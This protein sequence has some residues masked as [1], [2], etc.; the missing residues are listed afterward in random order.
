[1]TDLAEH[2]TTPTRSSPLRAGSTLAIGL[3]AGFGLG[4]VARAWMRLISED[5]EFT[6]AGTLFIVVGF[7]IC[8]FV[9]SI[10]AVAR[11]RLTQRWKLTIVRIIGAVA[12]LPLFVA[13]GAL[14]FPTVLGCGLALTRGGW[15]RI[16]RSLWL[17]VAAFPVVFVSSQLVGS[18][19]WSLHAL[20]GFVSMIAVYAPVV[21]ATRFTFA[22]Q[23]DGWR[24]GHW[25]TVAISLGA[26][27]LI[28]GVAVGGG[29]IK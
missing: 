5:P 8:G 24:R 9:Q 28:V 15:R 13:A 11:R 16:T 6:W 1:M 14:M 12:M 26:G 20:A 7:T 21:W 17:V 3:T 25:W 23:D 19:G 4:V 10:V 27:L 22:A 18:F 2:P 29:G